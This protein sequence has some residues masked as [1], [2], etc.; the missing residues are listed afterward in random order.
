LNSLPPDGG[1]RFTSA[2][3]GGTS[4]TS[5]ATM[6]FAIPPLPIQDFIKHELM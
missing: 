1:A 5:G 2:Q 3:A 6:V 4:I